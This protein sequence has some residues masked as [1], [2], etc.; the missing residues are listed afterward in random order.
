MSCCTWAVSAATL[1]SCAAKPVHKPWTVAI[2]ESCWDTETFSAQSCVCWVHTG[3]IVLSGLSGFGPKHNTPRQK[4]LSKVYSRFSE[5]K[6]TCLGSAVFQQKMSPLEIKG[7]LMN[8]CGVLIMNKVLEQ[9]E[10]FSE[11]KHTC[12]RVGAV[13]S[14][15]CAKDQK[16]HPCSFFSRCLTNEL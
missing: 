1:Q 5:Y 7:S 2:K 14:Q 9:K 13:L 12:L 16:L 3:Q 4:V 15:R 10:F 8:K 6:H 11:Y